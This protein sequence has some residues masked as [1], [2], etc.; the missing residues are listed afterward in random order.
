MNFHV[1]PSPHL[2]TYLKVSLYA[3]ASLLL[4]WLNCAPKSDSPLVHWIL[5]VL[6]SLS[7]IMSIA[8]FIMSE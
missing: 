5:A 3:L 8:F 7:C 1:L 2:P 6:L 4:L